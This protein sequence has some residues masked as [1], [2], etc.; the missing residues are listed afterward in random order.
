MRQLFK[1]QILQHLSRRDYS[2]QKLS[3]LSKSLCISGQ[4]YPE[5][6]AAFKELRQSGK[7]I[8]RAKNLISL[9][10]M[11]RIPVNMHN[12]PELRILRPSAWAA[13]GAMDPQGADFR[14]CATFGPQYGKY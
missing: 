8:I 3:A 11:L 14:A 10:S 1:N 12:V 6:K 7:V 5:F 2:P 13:F 9:A 4:D